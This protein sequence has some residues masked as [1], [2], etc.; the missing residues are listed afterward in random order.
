MAGLALGCPI[1]TNSGPSTETLWR[2]SQAVMVA[3]AA[4]WP[5]LV[6]AAEALL[7][8]G[9]GRAMLGA[10]AARLYKSRFALEHTLRELRL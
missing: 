2:E 4:S 10:R 3:P 9:A 6:S 1:V 5:A 7:A 8:D